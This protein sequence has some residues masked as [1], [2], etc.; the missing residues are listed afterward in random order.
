MSTCKIAPTSLVIRKIKIIMRYHY[1]EWLKLK[2]LTISNVGE[3][4]E[5][6]ELSYI[7][8]G[9]EK[10]FWKKF[11]QFLT[12]FN[13]YLPFDPS[14]PLLGIY[15]RK[16]KHMSTRKLVYKCSQPATTLSVKSVHCIRFQ[17]RKAELHGALI[18][19][20]CVIKS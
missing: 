10:P 4:I 14:I 1:T 20:K 8:G 7:T 17:S 2:K 15:L 19:L 9:N 11:W 13:I 18:F 6:V 5:Q 12:K 16:I 3:N